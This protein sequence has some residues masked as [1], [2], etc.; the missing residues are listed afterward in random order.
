MSESEIVRRLL[1]L[2]RQKPFVPFVIKTADGSRY[3]VTTALSF[4]IGNEMN[5]MVA[6]MGP[7]DRIYK[8]PRDTIVSIDVLE[9]AH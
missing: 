3:E 4:A 8:F 5:R 6:V 9:P 2:R 1:E 7:T